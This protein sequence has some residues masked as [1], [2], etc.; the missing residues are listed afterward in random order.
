[1]TQELFDKVQKA[2]ATRTRLVKNC[3]EPHLL[4]GLFFCKEC[5]RRMSHHNR[6]KSPPYYACGKYQSCGKAYCS[7]H[8]ILVGEICEIVLRKIQV[9]AQLL[10]DDEKQAVSEITAKKC[11][12][13]ERRFS[14][15]TKE[16]TKQKK[17]QSELDQ[18]IKRVYEDNFSGKISDSLFATFSQ[19]YENE[20]AALQTSIKELEETIRVLEA[21][22]TDVS[23]FVALLKE[24]TDLT[25][26]N[27]PALM[28]L[29]DRVDISE[30]RNA[31]GKKG[32]SQTIDIYF[33]YA[34]KL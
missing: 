23:K 1:M 14:T 21:N 17:R 18:R 33:N 8:F 13:E 7:S 5:G 28:A 12:D 11:A 30:P 27:R 6:K 22:R 3:S 32:H 34:G 25:E 26:L 19:D 4:S 10:Q 15:A 16:L 31:S 29:I 24:Y 9:T 20:R 2:I